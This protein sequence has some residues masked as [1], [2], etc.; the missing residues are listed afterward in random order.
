VLV[1]RA[2]ELADLAAFCHGPQRWRWIQADAFAGKTAVLATFVLHP[3]AN[4]DVAACFHRRATGQATADYILDIL[5]RQLAGHTA[6]PNYQPACLRQRID[7][8]LDLLARAAHAA[9]QRG[10]RLLLVVDGLDED[11]TDDPGLAVA[12]WL[13]DTISLPSNAWLLV[14][15]PPRVQW[16]LGSAGTPSVR[17]AIEPY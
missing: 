5:C 13:P 17:L 7:D 16:R 14:T 1:A 8:F 11:Q 4:V 2:D 12:E 3:P 9:D 15:E 10:H 6:K